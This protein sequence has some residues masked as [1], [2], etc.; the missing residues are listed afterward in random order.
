ME[1][2]QYVDV[3]L[4][5]SREHVKRMKDGLLTLEKQP[6]EMAVIQ[7][8]LRAT[9]TLKAMAQAM[10][11]HDMAELAHQLENIL[12]VMLKV[13]STVIEALFQ[14]VGTLEALVESFSKG[15]DR[16]Y[17]ADDRRDMSLNLRMMPVA[18][19]FGRFPEMVQSLAREL[20]KS[21]QLNI[22]GAD[23]ELDRAVIDEIGGSL[24]HMLRN[25]LD[26][27]IETPEVRESIGKAHKGIV[28]LKT[29]Y[30]GNDVVIEIKDDGSGINRESV[31]KKALK[32]RVITE[33]EAA[34]LSNREVYELLFLPRFSTAEVISDISGRG[35]GLDAVK[36]KIE[37]LG[38]HVEVDSLM[39]SGTTF[40]IQLPLTKLED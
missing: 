22:S 11:F 6:N 4:D 10:N 40:T 20:N 13:D 33:T 39:G 14:G 7:E 24:V 26:H 29:F 25:A 1:T 3:F 5:E 23:T 15:G 28:E 18:Q 9:H 19:T 8:I 27:G 34:R 17:P 30:S 2:D 21:V 32:S 16:K 36:N 37:S 38:G 31:L 12:D 35:V